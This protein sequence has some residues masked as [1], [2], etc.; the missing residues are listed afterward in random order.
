VCVCITH[1]IF[2]FFLVLYYL[3]SYRYWLL[4][5]LANV[6]ADV[7]LNPKPGTRS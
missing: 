6:V 4:I 3:H 2:R 1:N 5:V 7:Y